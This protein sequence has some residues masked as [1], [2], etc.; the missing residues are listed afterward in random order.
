M[1]QQ[2]NKIPF[3]VQI[4]K[5]G[6]NQARRFVG[7]CRHY[8]VSWGAFN[9]NSCQIKSS[10]DWSWKR[11]NQS[12]FFRLIQHQTEFCLIFKFSKFGLIKQ[13]D[14][15]PKLFSVVMCSQIKPS[16]DCNHTF[17]DW[18]SSIKLNSVWCWW[19]QSEYSKFG[20]IKHEDLS[21]C[22]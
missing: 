8:S 3:D 22:A 17:S 5:I 10:L 11:D 16:L 20:L 9:F 15:S 6:F 14:S 7:L 21:A 12:H 2:T 18:F 19:S 13:E 4:F 1:I